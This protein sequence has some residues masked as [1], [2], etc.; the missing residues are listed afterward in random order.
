[1]ALS[2]DEVQ[3]LEEALVLLLVELVEAG[4]CLDA[5]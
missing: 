4:P 1:M 3:G 2:R 5:L